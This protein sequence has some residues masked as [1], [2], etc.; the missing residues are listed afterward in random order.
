MR[1]PSSRPAMPACSATLALLGLLVAPAL[2]A[3]QTPDST[4]IPTWVRLGFTAG[5][6]DEQKDES[7]A[8]TAGGSTLEA[9]TRLWTG[10]DLGVRLSGMDRSWRN[11]EQDLAWGSVLL[12]GSWRPV[13]VE[14]E[15]GVVYDRRRAGAPYPL[16][17]LDGAGVWR[18]QVRGDMAEGRTVTVGT[19]RDLALETR[20]SSERR[21]FVESWWA[22]I[23]KEWAGWALHF[24]YGQDHFDPDNRR[25]S[26]EA[27]L[28]ASLA[29]LGA[30][31]LRAGYRFT[32]RDSREASWAPA[33]YF[34]GRDGGDLPWRYG[35]VYTPVDL[36]SHELLASY[37]GS[38][39]R[40]WPV[41]LEIAYGVYASDAQPAWTSSSWDY[42]L[43]DRTFHPWDVSG[44][45][46]VPLAEGVDLRF[47]GN[48]GENAFLEYW[49]LGTE[50]S[51]SFERARRR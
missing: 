47:R 3:A 28:Q 42:E 16:G 26:A 1:T 44:S 7:D 48:A 46:T 24:D 40:S 2:V 5:S 45:A 38:L 18:V 19:A 12:R 13:R 29:D 8:L 14:G 35:A 21:T 11:R 27:E 17:L 10:T 32:A 33:G 50:L 9:G 6:H 15:L 34:V 51:Y 30:P 43:R 22:G 36:R 20:V 31:G 39:N 37:R 25:W 4:T 23:G 49:A 41:A